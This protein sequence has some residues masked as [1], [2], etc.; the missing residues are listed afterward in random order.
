MART[1]FK[2]ALPTESLGAHAELEMPE[3]KILTVH[4]QYGNVIL[5][6][7]VDTET[8]LTK[9]YFT[10]CGTGSDVPPDAIY[11]G[12]AFVGPFVWHVYEDL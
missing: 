11:V 5:W 1:I 10:V 6:A 4:A 2:Y 8:P 7:E 9:R 3:A 12:T